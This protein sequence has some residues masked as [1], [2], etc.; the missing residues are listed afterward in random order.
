MPTGL[1]A[2]AKE[3]KITFTSPLDRETA[4]N[5]ESYLVEVWNY[6]W[7]G[8]YGS[9]E[10]S[11]LPEPPGQE[12]GKKKKTRDALEVKAAR[13][14]EDGKTLHLEID[15]LKPVMQMHIG[16][17]IAASDK[18]PVAFDIYNTVHELSGQ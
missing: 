6:K 11:T 1:N 7:T 3:M 12:K 14:S 5:P 13:L 2:T 4:T 9:A 10:Y 8:G 16:L 15:G 17:R 18:A